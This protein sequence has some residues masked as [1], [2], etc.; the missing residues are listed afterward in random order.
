MAGEN[1]AINLSQ[2]AKIAFKSSS[3]V[4]EIFAIDLSQMAKIAFK[5]S[6]MV[7]EHF[8]INLSQVAEIVC[9][10]LHYGWR[11]WLF[12]L[13]GFR[14]SWRK[15]DYTVQMAFQNRKPSFFV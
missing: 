8:A 15:N 2:I 11:P 5:S 1:F 3:M 14:R 9:T 12:L 7:G 4:G 10:I 6:T 13:R